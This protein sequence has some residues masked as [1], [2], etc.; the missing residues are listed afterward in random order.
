[1]RYVVSRGCV[2]CGSGLQHITTEYR[3]HIFTHDGGVLFCQL[4][5]RP[6]CVSCLATA[7]SQRA[8]QRDAALHALNCRGTVMQ[9]CT[10]CIAARL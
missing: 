8:R 5:R 2:E 1:M 6:G 3:F 10:P 4:F 9:R 7:T